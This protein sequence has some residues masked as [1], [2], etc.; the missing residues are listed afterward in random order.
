MDVDP[1]AASL[2]NH[3]AGQMAPG[4]T[5]EDGMVISVTLRWKGWSFTVSIAF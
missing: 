3:L 1:Y 2:D 4:T 5:E